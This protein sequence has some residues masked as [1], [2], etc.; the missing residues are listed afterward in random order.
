M[1]RSTRLRSFLPPG[2]RRPA[3]LIPIESP[4]ISRK[5]PA[6]SGIDEGFALVGVKLDGEPSAQ[7]F[8]VA[9]DLEA[10]KREALFGGWILFFHGTVVITRRRGYCQMMDLWD[11]GNRAGKAQWGAVSRCHGGLRL[12]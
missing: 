9:D 12:R 11:R 8:D 1:A 3:A 4:L 5:N 6:G 7:G 10:Q 2:L